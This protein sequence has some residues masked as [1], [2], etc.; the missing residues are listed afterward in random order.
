MSRLLVLLMGTLFS[1]AVLAG[2]PAG[3]NLPDWLQWL[4]SPDLA[5]IIFLF[6]LLGLVVEISSPGVILPGL[7]GAAGII[8][9]LYALQLM[10]ANM[11]AAVVIFAGLGLFFVPAFSAQLDKLA[12]VGLPVLG[13]GSYWLLNA[14]GLDVSLPVMVGFSLAAGVFFLWIVSR[15]QGLQRKAGVSG[16]DSL[17]GKTARIVGDFGGEGRVEVNGA[18]WSATGDAGLVDGEKVEIT[19]VDGLV[20]TVRKIQE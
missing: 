6:A 18:F 8:V 4:S 5:Y 3:A 13:L 16:H 20:L 14:P 7:A 10:G 11:W 17:I 12:W 2:P 19:A 15:L 9:S 1:T